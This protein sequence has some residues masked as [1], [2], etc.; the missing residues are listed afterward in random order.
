MNSTDPSQLFGYDVVDSSGDK[1]GTVDNVWVDDATSDLEFIGVKTGWLMGKTH[2]IPTADAQVGSDAIT[3]PYASDLVKD[4]PS[5][6]NDEL[7]PEEE[8]EVYSYYGIDRTTST[9][10][11]GEAGG[12]QT[13]GTTS[14]YGTTDAAYAGTD[15][16]MTDTTDTGY[17]TGNTDTGYT[18]T[19]RDSVRLHEEELQVGKR[20]VETGRVR[21][22][23]VVR[24]EQREVPVELRREEIQIERVPASGTDIASDAFQED[25]IEVPVM[26]EEAVVGKETRATGEVRLNK[27]VET[28]TRSVG[29]EIRRE[30]VEVDGDDTNTTGYDTTTNRDR[31]NSGY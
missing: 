18:G 16:N 1:I 6:G 13:T 20:E 3:I 4:A 24:T 22:R 26:R 31:S 19:D 11:T 12:F 21:L 30:D 29:G 23:K 25:S 14:D 7:S 15:T 9:S 5:F 27:N 8:E 28:E 2:I 17:A 10:P